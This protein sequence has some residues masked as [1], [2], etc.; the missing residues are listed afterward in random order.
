MQVSILI[1]KRSPVGESKLVLTVTRPALD[2]MEDKSGGSRLLVMCLSARAPQGVR[3]VSG[4]MSGGI[5]DGV[6]PQ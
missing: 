6:G 3:I 4:G 1:P 5:V 2:D